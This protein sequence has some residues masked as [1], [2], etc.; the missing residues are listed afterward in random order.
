M[1][2]ESSVRALDHNNNQKRCRHHERSAS[3]RCCSAQHAEH[4][5]IFLGTTRMRLTATSAEGRSPPVVS[6][7]RRNLIGP[8]VAKRSSQTC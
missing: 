4:Y 8:H 3:A 5:S 1:I 2:L 7:L 6:C